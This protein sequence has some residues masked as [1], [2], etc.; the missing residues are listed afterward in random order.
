MNTS[1][2]RRDHSLDSGDF[3]ASKLVNETD[4]DIDET[5]QNM[6]LEEYGKLSMVG[7][8]NHAFLFHGSEGHRLITMDCGAKSLTIFVIKGSVVQLKNSSIN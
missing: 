1:R 6:R 3:S 7:K 2:D 5:E 8:V 4:M